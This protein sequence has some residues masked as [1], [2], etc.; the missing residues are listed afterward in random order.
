MLLGLL[1]L[2]VLLKL[3]ASSP[4][5]GLQLSSSPLAVVHWLKNDS[6]QL[7]GNTN[8][9]ATEIM[10]YAECRGSCQEMQ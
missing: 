1:C 2:W 6:P 7:L 8:E 10:N 3:P 4:G 5:L 9:H